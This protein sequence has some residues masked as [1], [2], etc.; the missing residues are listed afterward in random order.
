MAGT[1]TKRHPLV[2][3]YL[4]R[5]DAAARPLP[6]ARRRDLLADTAAYLDQAIKPD[7]SAIE[8]RGLLGTL[9]TPEALAAQ[10]R[11]KPEGDPSANELPAITLLALGGL[12]IGIGWFIGVYLL[13][14]SRTFTLT[15]KL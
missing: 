14:R 4:R 5:L 6:R 10:D 9:G 8:V 3:D 2:E 1:E 13:W 12:F 11:P 7:S 15:D